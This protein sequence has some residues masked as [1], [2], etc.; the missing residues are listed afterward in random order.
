MPAGDDAVSQVADAKTTSV[1]WNANFH[2]VSDDGQTLNSVPYCPSWEM[3][4]PLY[5]VGFVQSEMVKSA[6]VSTA[7]LAVLSRSGFAPVNVTSGLNWC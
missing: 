1:F 7:A 4:L 2:V 5:A 6:F 3:T